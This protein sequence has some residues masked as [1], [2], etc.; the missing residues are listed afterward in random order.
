MGAAARH[1]E[2]VEFGAQLAQAVGADVD[3]RDVVTLVAEAGG[4]VGA[5]L[6]GPNDDDM[7]DYV[8]A[9]RTTA[10]RDQASR[11]RSEMMTARSVAIA[12]N[13]T[14]QGSRGTSSTCW[15]QCATPMAAGLAAPGPEGSDARARS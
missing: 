9:P 12:S 7:H 14:S 4:H 10:G 2:H 11:P 15:N 13:G 3:H 5:D 6:A 1:G 8:L